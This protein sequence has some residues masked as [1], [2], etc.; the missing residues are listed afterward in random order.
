MKTTCVG[1]VIG[2]VKKEKVTIDGHDV[3]YAPTHIFLLHF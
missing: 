2:N 3:C 1:E